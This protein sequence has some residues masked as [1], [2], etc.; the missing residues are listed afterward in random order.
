MERDS[1]T[2]AV[3]E[4]ETC[5]WRRILRGERWAAAM[6]AEDGVCKSRRLRLGISCAAPVLENSSKRASTAGYFSRI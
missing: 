1:V 6:G 3:V 5:A 2:P 4:S